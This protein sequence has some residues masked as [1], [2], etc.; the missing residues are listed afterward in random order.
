MT[1]IARRTLV[2][3][4]LLAVM[5]LGATGAGAE[6]A[7]VASPWVHMDTKY[8][9]PYGRGDITSVKVKHQASAVRLTLRTRI[10]S[11]PDSGNPWVSGGTSI[12]WLI[13]VNDGGTNEFGAILFNTGSGVEVD[14]YRHVSGNATVVC[15]ADW[16][17]PNRTTFVIEFPRTCISS[18][19]SFRA[20]ALMQ[21]NPADGR[22]A[23][24]DW[25]PNDATWSPRITP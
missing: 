4:S 16:S 10:G 17:H 22:P 8:D 25:S 14:V 15:S 21:Y 24:R 1:R 13:D 6:S 12:R 3:V 11:N 18:P 2:A 20:L 23:S 19:P 5:T 9:V 7:V